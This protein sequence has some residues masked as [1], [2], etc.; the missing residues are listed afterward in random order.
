MLQDIIDS[1]HFT[2]LLAYEQLEPRGEKRQDIRSAMIA[3]TIHN[4]HRTSN[5]DKTA[6][7]KDYLL[8]FDNEEDQDVITAR[9][10]AALAQLGI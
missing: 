10:K 8:T 3:A 2:E 7:I 4:C 5:K 1:R 9:N 6:N